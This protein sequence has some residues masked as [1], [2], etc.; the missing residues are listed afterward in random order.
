MKKCFLNDTPAVASPVLQYS[1]YLESES[2][3]NQWSGVSG[4]S[5]VEGFPLK[6]KKV[7]NQVL[8]ADFQT[9]VALTTE[10]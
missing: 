5:R 9:E 1:G 10:E 4:G 6:I 2:G 7:I 3:Y 8:Q